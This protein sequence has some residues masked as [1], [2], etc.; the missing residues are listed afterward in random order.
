MVLPPLFG[1]LRRAS[2]LGAESIKRFWRRERPSFRSWDWIQ[3]SEQSL[4]APLASARSARIAPFVL[5]YLVVARRR[6]ACLLDPPRHGEGR[7]PCVVSATIAHRS[8][9]S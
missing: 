6:K 8:M 9:T 3:V 5:A 1:P 7:D 2:H 4:I